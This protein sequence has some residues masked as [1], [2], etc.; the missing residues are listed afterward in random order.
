MHMTKRTVAVA[1]ASGYAGGEVLRLLLAHPDVE[2]GAHHGRLQ[3]RRAARRPPAAPRAAGRPGARGDHPSRCSPATTSSSSA[4]PHGQSAALAKAAAGRHGRHRLRRRLPAHRPGGL[5]DV[6]RR[7]R[8]PAP[9]PTAC[10]SW[11]A[12]A[13]GSP[14][15][16]AIA[17]P[18]CYPTVSTLALAPAVAAG[19]VDAA[20]LVVVAASGTSRRRQG[21]QAQPARLGGDGL[22][23]RVRRR[24]HATGTPPRSPRTSPR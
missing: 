15:R 4:L 5:G 19:I 14:A 1:G 11:P 7:R 20:T 22:G 21:P 2:I 3:R 10:P 6:L 9:G 12:S 23:Q 18:G 13:S 8:T 24:R 17:V 16:P